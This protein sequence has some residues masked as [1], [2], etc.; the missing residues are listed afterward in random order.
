M[1]GQSVPYAR[2]APMQPESPDVQ[3][4]VAWTT[5]P[6]LESARRLGR[7]L[8]EHRLA[9]CATLVPGALSIYHW[10][11]NIEESSEVQVWLKTT[12]A[13]RA[14]L[15]ARLAL[16]H[17]Y[18]VPELVFVTLEHVL[19]AYRAWMAQELGEA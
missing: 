11:G 18:Q 4:L 8:V 13:K 10:Q 14:A 1:G 5:L 2:D 7:D 19:P 3:P 17:P 12:G 16:V 15:Q 9:A 6:D